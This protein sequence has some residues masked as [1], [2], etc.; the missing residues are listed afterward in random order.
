MVEKEELLDEYPQEAS[1]ESPSEKEDGQICTFC[2]HDVEVEVLS[3][4]NSK[5]MKEEIPRVQ[6]DTSRIIK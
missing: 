3:S 2:P 5:E 6:E 4:P 1:A